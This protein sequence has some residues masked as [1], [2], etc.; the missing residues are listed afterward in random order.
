M[1]LFH[2]HVAII[3]VWQNIKSVMAVFYVYAYLG[4]FLKHDQYYIFLPLYIFLLVDDI[5]WL[6]SQSFPIF[7]T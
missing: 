7:L 1:N 3:V 5:F 2:S 6:F 4:E